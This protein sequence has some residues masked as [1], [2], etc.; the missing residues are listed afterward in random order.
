M[1]VTSLVLLLLACAGTSAAQEFQ[2]PRVRSGAGGKGLGLY[3]FGVR[4]GLDLGSG[5]M[6]FGTT[7][8][9]GSA[10][11]FDLK[12]MTDEVALHVASAD[13]P[14]N[15]VSAVNSL[16]SVAGSWTYTASASK[17]TATP[18]VTKVSVDL[19]GNRANVEY[20]VDLVKP[21]ALANAVRTLGYDGI[22]STTGGR[23]V[24]FGGGVLLTDDDGAVTGGVGVSAG[25]V[26]EDHQ[27]AEAGR[28]AYAG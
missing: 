18:G 26:D 3:G 9:I 13:S 19:A 15:L 22:E 16:H 25:T 8:D 12:G 5:Q 21:E 14:D 23:L 6:V 28:K 24:V 4:G 27:V 17:D 20:D 2:P 11:G 7:L 10:T 1:K